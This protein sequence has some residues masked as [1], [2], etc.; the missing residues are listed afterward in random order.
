MRMTLPDVAI[1]RAQAEVS[2]LF[3]RFAVELREAPRVGKVQNQLWIRAEDK[4][5]ADHV[6][7]GTGDGFRVEW[8]LSVELD[9]GRWV[10]VGVEL[11]WHDG[12]WTVGGRIHGGPAGDLETLVELPT[13]STED[14]QTAVTAVCEAARSALAQW[15]DA[16][17][18]LDLV[19]HG[20]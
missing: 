8:W 4:V 7:V 1:V 19:R 10:D 16:L 20:A 11:A 17:F 3:L 18:R 9:G 14:G 15:D 13:L 6:R 2:E 12:T 5:G